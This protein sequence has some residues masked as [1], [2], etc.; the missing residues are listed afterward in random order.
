MNSIHIDKVLT[1]HVKYL[2]GVYPIDLLPSTL[3]KPSII[4]ININNCHQ[5][6][7]HAR[8]ALGSCLFF[9]LWIC[10][11]FWFVRP[12]TIQTRNHGIPPAPLN[13]LNL[14]P[15]QTTGFNHECLRSL[16]LHLRTPQSQWTIRDV[17][18]EHVLTC[19]LHLQR[20]KSSAHVS[21]S[22]SIVVPPAASCWSSSSRASR[23][24]K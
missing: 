21:R 15:P 9:R 13:F 18:C 1:K 22:V 12:T 20:Y 24:Y 3:I 19:T 2:Q 7:L 8:I 16:L 4:V 5:E 10:R 17:I 6:T 14:Q 11:I 23:R